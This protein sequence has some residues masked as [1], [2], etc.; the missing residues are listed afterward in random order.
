MNL[1]IYLDQHQK[2]RQEIAVLEALVAK[3]NVANNASEIVATINSLA[4]K[5]K[6]H[7]SI[8][9][10]YLYPELRKKADAAIPK[11]VEESICEISGL[12]AEFTSYKNQFNTKTKLIENEAEFAASTNK[13]TA[14]ITK[15]MAKEETGIYTYI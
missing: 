15:R 11:V 6:V 4:G 13:I 14:A 7:L 2:I 5:L 3:K 9:D 10:K 12:A 8:E 1:T